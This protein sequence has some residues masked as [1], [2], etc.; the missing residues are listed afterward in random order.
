V[1]CRAANPGT[2]WWEDCLPET[3]DGA[4]IRQ[5]ARSRQ[6]QELL[7]ENI[8]LGRELEIAA[9]PTYLL[10]NEEIFGSSMAPTKEE[11]RKIILEK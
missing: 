3:L 9:G 1:R 2:A 4:V 5:C 6:G 11:F 7:R 8:A 10:D